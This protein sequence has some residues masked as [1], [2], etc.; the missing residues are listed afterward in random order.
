MTAE[1]KEEATEDAMKELTEG[2]ELQQA[3]MQ[4]HVMSLFQDTNHNLNVI[5][6]EVH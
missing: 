4:N 1:E 3:T 6:K 2:L 5:E